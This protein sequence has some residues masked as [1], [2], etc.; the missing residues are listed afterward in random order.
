[1]HAPYTLGQLTLLILLKYLAPDLTL[2]LQMYTR[3][4]SV[5]YFDLS[6]FYY[7]L[8]FVLLTF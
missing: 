2:R 5:I 8:N 6:V 1:M 7:Y 3:T 4:R